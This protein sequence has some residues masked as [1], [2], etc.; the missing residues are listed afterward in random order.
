MPERLKELRSRLDEINARLLELLEDRAELVKEVA[1]VKEQ[2]QLPTLDSRRE[3]EML[4]ALLGRS[5]GRLTD[6]QIRAIFRHVFSIARDLIDEAR[7]SRLGVHASNRSGPTVVEVGRVRIGG[8]LPPV[9]LAGPCSLES[10]AQAETLLDYFTSRL[11]SERFLF[12]CGLDKPRT[13]PYSFQGLGRE[14][15][16]II[17]RL[18]EKYDFAVVSEVTASRHIEE[19]AG[20]VDMWQVGARNMSNFELLRD[21]GR[22]GT[23]VLLKRG[24]AA[25]IEELLYAAEY[26]YASGNKNV[27]LCERGIRTFEPWT[28]FTLDISAVPIIKNISHLPIIVDVSHSTGRKDVAGSIAAAALAAGADGV[29]VEVHPDPEKALSDANQQLSLAEFALFLEK[30]FPGSR[31]E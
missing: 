26:I 8:G 19:F 31:R 15:L 30:A 3:E 29:M 12:R 28:R 25:T 16:E 17:S 9:L 22:A 24:Y 20:V 13:S 18:K 27:V 14:G 7:L 5:R 4:A 23:P 11:P 10:R 21:L 2:A 1:L 6:V